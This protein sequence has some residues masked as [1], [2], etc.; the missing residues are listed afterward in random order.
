MGLT[1]KQ[2]KIEAKILD[3]IYVRGPISRIDIA[4]ET[5]ITP[6]TVSSTTGY[7][8]EDQLIEEIGEDPKSA[9]SGRRKILLDIKKNH[10]YFVGME[11]SEKFISMCL[12]D[13]KANLIDQEILI[14][15]EDEKVNFLTTQNISLLINS[16]IQK[17]QQL[18]I[19]AIG[20]ALPG[21]H[22]IKDNLLLTNNPIWNNIDLNELEKNIG[23]PMFFE[24]NV[25]SMLIYK[26]FFGESSI[27][28]NF[29]LH[30][31]SRGIFCAYMYEGELYAQENRLVG[32][33]GHTTIQVDG[34]LCE[35]GNHGCLQTFSSE[36]WLIKKAQ[37]IFKHV[38][39]TYLRKIVSSPSEITFKT[40][41]MAYTLGDPLIINLLQDAIQAIATNIINLSMIID[42][43]TIF[44]HG[45]IYDEPDLVQLLEELME[46]RKPLFKHENKPRLKVMP[47]NK[48]NGALGACALCTSEIY[49]KA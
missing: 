16:F 45:N 1:K 24:N 5:G 13:N 48:I 36:T 17:F 22:T 39:T 37:Y 33:V 8:I 28:E 4:H 7:L 19:S 25:K 41:L 11:L 46:Q 27:D 21:H 18:N 32:E 38:E 2:K 47:Y 15:E 35:C 12:T 14:L 23:I 34:E 3:V 10:K 9:G 29:M 6:A 26:R 49:T 31:I 20:V 44:V 30:H 42:A 40:V 43:Q